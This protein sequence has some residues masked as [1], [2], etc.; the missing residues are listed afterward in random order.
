M[1]RATTSTSLHAYSVRGALL[2]CDFA[3]SAVLRTVTALP[4]VISLLHCSCEVRRPF[5]LWGL[6]ALLPARS[7]HTR[8]A[9]THSAH[10]W[11]A[12]SRYE[13]DIKNAQSLGIK[14]FRLSIEW[15]RLEPIEGMVDLSAVNRCAPSISCLLAVSVARW[16]R[17]DPGGNSFSKAEIC[18]LPLSPSHVA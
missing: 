10:T 4:V 3:C 11:S 17:L 8:S 12:G 1:A 6:T 2:R 5:C 14:A 18:L 13:E 9:S 7:A 16:V 15:H